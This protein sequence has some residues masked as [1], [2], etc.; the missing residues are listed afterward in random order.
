MQFNILASLFCWE[1]GK[2]K[3]SVEMID[4]SNLQFHST[5]LYTLKEEMLI[6]QPIKTK[7]IIFRYSTDSLKIV[8]RNEY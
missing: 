5:D 2:L 4:F 7:K 6:F 8:Y 3:V 1:R